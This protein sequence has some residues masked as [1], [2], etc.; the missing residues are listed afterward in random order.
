MEIPPKPCDWTGIEAIAEHLEKHLERHVDGIATTLRNEMAPYAALPLADLLPGV[1]TSLRFGIAGLKERR[2]PSADERDELAAVAEAR[3]Y[4][5]IPLD[6]VL[7]A[8]RTSSHGVWAAISAEA[9]RMGIDPT[10]LLD[11]VQLVW[12]WTDTVIACAAGAHRRAELEL[13]RTHQQH[14]SNFLVALTNGSL[15]APDLIAQAYAHGLDPKR[16]YRAFRAQAITAAP[17]HVVERTLVDGGA[18]VVGIINGVLSGVALERLRLPGDLPMTVGMGPPV[19]LSVVPSS[20]SVAARV[21]RAATGFAMTGVY[22]LE[23]L[24]LKIPIRDEDAVG[25]ML[26]ERYVQPLRRLRHGGIGIEEAVRA[27]LAEGMRIEPAARRLFIHPNTLRYRLN[28]FQ[29]ITGADLWSTDT[30]VEVWWALHRLQ[31]SAAAHTPSET[32]TST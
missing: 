17:L 9:Y 14:R 26:V 30:L 16:D 19:E 29:E 12:A 1:S 6:L 8:Y 25:D 5:G 7:S 21:F 2:L 10:T 22:E 32:A 3:A 4:Q 18:V 11:V 28:K 24:S 27:L 20:F 13:A 15:A 23:D 31:L